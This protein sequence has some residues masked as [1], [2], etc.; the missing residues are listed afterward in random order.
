MKEVFGDR[1]LSKAIR[2]KGTEE[3]EGGQHVLLSELG[4]K[5][6]V[7]V[8]HHLPNEAADSDS[9]SSSSED[10]DEKAYKKEKKSA[11]ATIIVP[12]LA[13]LGVYAQSVKPS[14]NSWFEEVALKNAPHHHLINVS[15]LGLAAH[16]PVHATKIAK[17]NSQHL[18]R[19]FPKGTRISSKNLNPV[20]F[21]AVGSQ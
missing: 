18:M 14:D 20:P 10:E 4:S 19:V 12:E 8:E 3:Q 16:L 9:S 5:I 15:E 6:V 1:L 17:H 7:I 21:W 13:E 11:P 2:E